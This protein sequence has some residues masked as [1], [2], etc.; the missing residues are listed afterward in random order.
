MNLNGVLVSC[1]RSSQRSILKA[2]SRTANVYRTSVFDV[3]A[4]QC[5]LLLSL[6]PKSSE[7]C[8]HAGCTTQPQRHSKSILLNR[9]H[10]T[11]ACLGMALYFPQGICMCRCTQLVYDVNVCMFSVD[12]YLY[13]YIY[14]YTYIYIYILYLFICCIKRDREI[15]R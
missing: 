1:K 2:L 12:M 14:I 15:D 6:E 8:A 7:P 4:V 9:S 10:C 13:L 3:C 11:V 5:M